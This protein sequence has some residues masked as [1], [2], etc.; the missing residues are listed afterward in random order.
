M[1]IRVT[2]TVSTAIAEIIVVSKRE[3]IPEIRRKNNHKDIKM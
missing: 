2:E 1:D 3:N